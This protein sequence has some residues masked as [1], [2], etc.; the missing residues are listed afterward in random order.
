[1]GVKVAFSWHIKNVPGDRPP[2]IGQLAETGVIRIRHGWI[3]RLEQAA[4]AKKDEAV[5][6]QTVECPEGSTPV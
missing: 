5:M 3:G 6:V 4:L 2:A 1:M